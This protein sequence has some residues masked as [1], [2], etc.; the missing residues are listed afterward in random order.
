MKISHHSLILV[1]FLICSF[2]QQLLVRSFSPNLSLLLR[3]HTACRTLSSAYVLKAKSDDVTGASP[4]FIAHESKEES[5]SE[6]FTLVLQSVI[7]PDTALEITKLCDRIDQA[8]A[9]N[10]SREEKVL[11]SARMWALTRMLQRDRQEYLQTVNFLL[12]RIPR[13]DLPNLQ[14]LGT[15]VAM[16]S[17]TSIQGGIETDLVADCA[18][19]NITFTES[20][21]D[22]V[23]LSIFRGLVQKEI[24]FKSEKKGIAGLLAEGRHYMLSPEGTELNQHTF[25]KN[26]LGGLMTPFLPPFYR[27]FMSGIV[28]SAERG[29][30]E[31]LVRKIL[32]GKKLFVYFLYKILF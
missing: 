7:L 16:S 10:R 5:W 26:V 13:E 23:L 25:V 19:P 6:L 17:Y 30:P 8:T 9:T 22:R 1:F 24:S 15:A 3:H 29:D 27:L 20:L 31:W 2:S 11:R 18:L 28:P 4:V 12:R 21:L 32:T 14:D